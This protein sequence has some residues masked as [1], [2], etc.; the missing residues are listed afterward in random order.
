MSDQLS[1]PTVGLR[2][3]PNSYTSELGVITIDAHGRIAGMNPAAG[4]L[5]C[6]QTGAFVQ[7]PL[8]DLLA[9][10]CAGPDVA[11]IMEAVHRALL[12]WEVSIFELELPNG[13]ASTA[14]VKVHISAIRNRDAGEPAAVLTLEDI[15]AYSP[16]CTMS[17][18]MTC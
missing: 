10:L 6:I 16:R 5:L 13:E 8:S 17:P 18:V 4:V 1:R 14:F 12:I 9:R 3:L 2:K 15:T 11:Y 7:R